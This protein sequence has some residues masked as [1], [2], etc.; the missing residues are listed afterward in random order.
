MSILQQLHATVNSSDTNIYCF[1][2]GACI[3]NGKKYAKASWAFI[4]PHDET[5]N[6]NGLVPSHST[7]NRA[8]IIAIIKAIECYI[9]HN[10]SKPL[11]IFTDSQY[12]IDCIYK[13]IQS[14][15][16]NGWKTF[17]NKPVDNKDLLEILD[18][19]ILQHNIH[20]QW[21]PAH[22]NQN[23]WKSIY[24]HKVDKLAKQLLSHK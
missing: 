9:S 6:H 7:N 24:N 8:E 2:D 18:K 22:T 15:K 10:F 20:I 1:T 5:L 19:L 13:W 21:I 17:K 3:N 11:Y 16:K 14:W 4:F 12:V 23:D